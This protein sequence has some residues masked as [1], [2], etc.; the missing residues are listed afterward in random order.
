MALDRLLVE[1][2]DLSGFGRPSRGADR[3]RDR[4]ES[5]QSAAR[6]EHPRPLAAEGPSHC[7]ADR[8]A[9]SIDDRALIASN[10]ESSFRSATVPGRAGRHPL[11]QRCPLAGVL[12]ERGGTVEF[13]T[14][15][16]VAAEL[17]EQVAAHGRQ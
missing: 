2:V 6:E 11:E 12:G 8:A 13:R 17:R 10:I 1:G 14:R 16:V 5:R 9:A 3:L 7:P 4:F 15:L